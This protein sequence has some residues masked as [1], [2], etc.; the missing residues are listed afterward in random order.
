MC[1][2]FAVTIGPIYESLSQTK[3]TRQLWAA[4]Y[5]FSYLIKKII[6]ILGKDFVIIS[7][8]FDP[9]FVNTTGAG[10]YPDRIY[11]YAKTTKTLAD[12]KI[13]IDEVLQNFAREINCHFIT[14][15][16]KLGVNDVF[17]IDATA[18]KISYN[19]I[20]KFICSYF[21]YYT[22]TLL[23]EEGTPILQPLNIMLDTLEL[24]AKLPDSKLP[25][26]LAE[27][28]FRSLNSPLVEDAF[29]KNWHHFNS[30]FQISSVEL[31]EKASKIKIENKNIFNSFIK[32]HFTAIHRIEQ[33]KLSKTAIPEN[34]Q[35]QVTNFL[36]NF[37]SNVLNVINQQINIV[38]EKLKLNPYHKYIA[39]VYADG[40]NIGKAIG[41]LNNVQNIDEFSK[42]LFDFSLVASGLIEKYGAMPVYIGGDDMLF[43]APVANT[44]SPNAQHI[45]ALVSEIDKLYAECA[46]KLTKIEAKYKYTMSYS[47][48]ITYFKFPLYE[49]MRLGFDN[50]LYKAKNKKRFPNKNALN[51]VIQKHSGQMWE[52]AH[53]K[54]ISYPTIYQEW[55]SFVN[56]YI[57]KEKLES[58]Y[59]NSLTHK[60]ENLD[61]LFKQSAFIP[62]GIK[63]F[64]EHSFNEDVHKNSQFITKLGALTQFYYT[65][66]PDQAKNIIFSMLRYIDFFNPNKPE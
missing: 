36:A 58:E 19:N 43:F 42:H 23:I 1:Q 66:C 12:L 41:G 59:L 47:I 20:Y 63:N 27:Y 57:L 25:N 37:K 34:D 29:N 39:I 9:K 16:S 56:D 4:S 22:T 7:P 51:V 18:F 17:Y 24:T 46:E 8:S 55:M 14:M 33:S 13:K 3:E 50:L 6:I 45:L 32:N 26:Y 30:L 11:C 60:I 40:D 64:F 53:T 65:K 61:S 35:T 15:C 49:S 62:N 54:D 28:W 10:L 5:T 21:K 2:Y 38:T 48:V 31:T 52:F 44:Q